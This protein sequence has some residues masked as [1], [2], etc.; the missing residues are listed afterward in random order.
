MPP[1]SFQTWDD[2][3]WHVFSNIS[4]SSPLSFMAVARHKEREWLNRIELGLNAEFEIRFREAYLDGRTSKSIPFIPA[5][6]L[7]SRPADQFLLYP[8]RKNN[9]TFL[10]FLLPQLFGCIYF[11]TSGNFPPAALIFRGRYYSPRLL[12]FVIHHPANPT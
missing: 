5:P 8:Q 10:L 9:S 4:P 2:P 6:L 11:P 12:F 3:R 1:F 7:E